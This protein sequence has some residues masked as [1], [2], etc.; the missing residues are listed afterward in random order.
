MAEYNGEKIVM[1][2]LQ[3]VTDQFI[4]DDYYEWFEEFT[5]LLSTESFY[6]QPFKPELITELFDNWEIKDGYNYIEYKNS[7]AI[8]RIWH[9]EPNEI[10]IF[11][12]K[13]LSGKSTFTIRTLDDFI[14][15]CQRAGIELIWRSK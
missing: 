3:W 8:L 5:D 1:S 11:K 2:Y 4:P 15:D 14:C 10:I 7:G 9:N 13:V 6:A 12:K